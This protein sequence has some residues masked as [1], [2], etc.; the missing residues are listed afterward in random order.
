MKEGLRLACN[1]LNEHMIN[2]AAT[3]MN[4][5][6]AS[7]PLLEGRETLVCRLEWRLARAFCVVDRVGRDYEHPQ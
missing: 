5:L 7:G 2:S 6:K 1:S 3:I 4:D